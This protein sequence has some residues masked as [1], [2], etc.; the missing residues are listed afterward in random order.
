MTIILILIRS[1][2]DNKSFYPPTKIRSNAASSPS[3]EP[4]VVRS[5]TGPLV[6]VQGERENLL[7]SPSP[8]DHVA[9]SSPPPI[10]INNHFETSCNTLVVVAYG[11]NAVEGVVHY[12][13][14]RVT[15][16]WAERVSISTFFY[17]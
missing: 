8:V 17:F 9:S 6:Y 4:A 10:K 13:I 3:R 11:W 5:S 2:D 15:R 1:W 12:A 16:G 14:L 7:P